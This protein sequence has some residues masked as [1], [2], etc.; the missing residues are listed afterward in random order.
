MDKTVTHNQVVGVTH[1]DQKGR[2]VGVNFREKLPQ[3]MRRVIHKEWL[4]LELKGFWSCRSLL[5]CERKI[6]FHFSNFYYWFSLTKSWTKSWLMYQLNKSLLK[7]SLDFATPS[8][9]YPLCFY[10]W[11]SFLP[12]YHSLYTLCSLLPNLFL[13]PFLY[14]FVHSFTKCFSRTSSCSYMF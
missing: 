7:Y 8:S 1:A 13:H 14:C 3:T 12:F 4:G 2:T 9:H 5:L 11:H 6:S 10:H